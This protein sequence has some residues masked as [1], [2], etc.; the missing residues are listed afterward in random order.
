MDKSAILPI[1]LGVMIL[2]GFLWLMTT[3]TEVRRQ[4]TD[5]CTAAGGI[6]VLR[7]GGSFHF[8]MNPDAI[9]TLDKD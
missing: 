3:T 5:E 1:V 9:I 8:C 2:L 7:Q 6:S 4:L